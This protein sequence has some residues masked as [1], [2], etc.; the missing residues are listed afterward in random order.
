MKLR[1]EGHLPPAAWRERAD[2]GLLELARLTA[3]PLRA[4]RRWAPERRARELARLRAEHA[5]TQRAEREAF[6]AGLADL[7]LDDESR[8]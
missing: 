8:L 3:L 5:A 4:L 7:H 6:L 2:P 1:D